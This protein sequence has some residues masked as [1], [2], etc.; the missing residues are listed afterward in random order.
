MRLYL[1]ILIIASLPAYGCSTFRP[2]TVASDSAGLTL[3]LPGI[4]G[5]SFISSNTA[6][7]LVDGQVTGR[8][9]VFDWT[10]GNALRSLE[11]LRDRERVREQSQRLLERLTESHREDAARPISLVAHSGGA[12]VVLQALEQLP[13]EHSVACVVLLAPAVSA[14][15]PIDQAAR[16]PHGGV[17]SFYSPLDIQLMAGTPL[18]GTIDGEHV[19][20]AG[21]KGF[22]RAAAG[23]TQIPYEPSMLASGN[24]GGHLGPTGRSFVRDHVAPLIRRGQLAMSQKRP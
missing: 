10:S 8:I 24:F 14:D 5:D 11:H 23:L 2:T 18:A 12:G 19:I 17:W 4:G 13:P 15:Y 20:A 3:V 22:T 1:L 21:G 7:G 6:E 16:K 9:E